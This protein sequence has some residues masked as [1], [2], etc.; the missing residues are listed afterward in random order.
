MLDDHPLNTSDHLPIIAELLTSFAASTLPTTQTIRQSTFNWSKCSSQDIQHLY[1]T[2]LQSS[3]DNLYHQLPSQAEILLQPQLLDNI[4]HSFGNCLKASAKNIPRKRYHKHKVPKWSHD[5]KEAQ[6]D[7]KCAYRVWVSAGRPRSVDHPARLAYKETK[8]KFRACLRQHRRDL[9]T[10]F[11]ESLDKKCS[12]PQRLFQSIRNHINPAN[13][14]SSLSKLIV[15]GS[16]FQGDAIL[17]GW[18]NYFESLSIPHNTS[19]TPAQL[20]IFREY[21]S[22]CSSNGICSNEFALDEVTN[23]ICS[24]PHRKAAGPDG[25]DNEH[26]IFGGPMVSVCLTLIFNSILL[27]RYIPE[28]FRHAYV[29]PILKSHNKD[30]SNPSNYRGISLLS[31]ISKVFE[32][33]LLSR[34]HDLTESLNPLQGG[35]RSGYSC[36]HTAFIL[37]E[38][39]ASQREKKKKVYVAFLDAKKAFDTVWHTG[40]MVKLHQKKIPL[41][42]WHML[43]YWYCN[44]SALVRWNN[45]SSRPFPIKQGVRQGAI[46]SPLLYSVYVDNL[47]DTLTSSGCGVQIES[48][49]C[50]APMYADDLALIADS[51]ADLQS[52]LHIVSSYA[53]LWR[54]E[55]NA[56]KSSVLVLGES[57]SSRQTA[58]AKRHW[59]IQG[60]A[61]QEQD[62]Q[63]HLG[64]LQSVSFSTVTRT[65]ERCSAG[66]SAFYALNAIG[67]RFGCLHPL[68]SFHLYRSLCIPIMLYG[69][70]LWS[71]TKTEISIL[72]RVHHKILRTIQGLP[73]RCRTSAVHSLLGATCLYDVIQQRQLTFVNSFSAMASDALP[74][75]IFSARVQ[76]TANK[77]SIPVWSTLLQ[78]L[79]LPDLSQL[80]D[81]PWSRKS[82]KKFVKCLLK[83]NSLLH[84][85]LDCSHLPI[86]QC[87]F[88]L[89]KPLPHWSVTR[90]LPLLTRRNNFRIRL[91]VGCDGLEHDACRFRTRRFP[92]AGHSSVCKLCLQESEDQAHFIA[93]CPRLEPI[94][95]QLLLTAPPP[96]QSQRRNPHQ[97]VQVILGLDWIE[98]H[99]TQQFAINFLHD[100]RLYW[101]QLLSSPQ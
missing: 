35:F 45:K 46:L 94:R 26:L 42:I 7:S 52:M 51:V 34:L 98:D 58:R 100:L 75:M 15:N 89:D 40:L 95:S 10:D 79:D 57:P 39:I 41:Y 30:P 1:T 47:L 59:H 60:F 90:S 9:N 74:R 50:G 27:C 70:E 85:Q 48:I 81:S 86:S 66:R 80:M 3:L 12:D 72:E 19:F 49:Y 61:V 37:Q 14:T 71:V 78:S 43:N 76:S 77:G 22:I 2:P 68:T 96:V 13:A 53:S 29:I 31:A 32:K 4:L 8:K 87:S 65:V 38:A 73:T 99:V 24:L 55:F 54:Y 11:Y 84:H 67:S 44:S 97:L 6:R 63:K 23:A 21:N 36:L 56:Q 62:N 92:D 82:W 101:N 18:A 83:T 28:C 33:L 69:C 5:L 16:E 17:D 88:E 64:I 25:I 93:R 91:L 20:D